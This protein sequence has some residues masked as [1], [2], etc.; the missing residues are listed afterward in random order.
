M[1]KNLTQKVQEKKSTNVLVYK[2][3]KM[4]RRDLIKIIFIVNNE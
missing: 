3:K 2:L 1:F 4:K